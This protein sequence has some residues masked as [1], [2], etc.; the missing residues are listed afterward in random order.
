MVRSFSNR[1]RRTHWWNLT[2]SISIAF[3]R[4]AEGR[5]GGVSEGRETTELEGTKD[6]TYSFLCFQT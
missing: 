2:S 5:E 3:P 6:V 1:A 4:E